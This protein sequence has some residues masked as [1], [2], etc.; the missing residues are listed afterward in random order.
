VKDIHET[1]PDEEYRRSDDEIYTPV[2]D[3]QRIEAGG[4]YKRENLKLSTLPLGIRIIGYF[5]IGFIAI[6][7]FLGI[8]FSFLK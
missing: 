2:E 5:I 8:I 1:Q 3:L 7:S 4:I 6:T